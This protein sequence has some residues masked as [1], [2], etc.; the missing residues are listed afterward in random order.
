MWE[1]RSFQ[2]IVSCILSLPGEQ[3]ATTQ[4]Q[5]NIQHRGDCHHSVPTKHP[6]QRWLPPLTTNKTSNTEVTA[7]THYQQN[8]QHRGDCHHSVPTKHPTQR[9]LPPLT[10]NK[11]SNTE[12]TA[13]HHSISTEHPTQRWLPAITSINKTIFF[14]HNPCGGRK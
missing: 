2:F 1:V 11:T 14:K 7:T 12:V 4:Y 8:I 13:T 10:T 6:T 9:W 3:R 5:Q